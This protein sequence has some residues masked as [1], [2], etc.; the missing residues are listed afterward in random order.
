[1][2]KPQ[3]NGSLKRQDERPTQQIRTAWRITDSKEAITEMTRTELLRQQKA[4]RQRI[5][6]VVTERRIALAQPAMENV[7]GTVPAAPADCC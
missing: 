6:A 7:T 5:R 4:M 2:R 1:V 3:R